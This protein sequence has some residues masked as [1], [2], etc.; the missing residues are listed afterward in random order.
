M[1]SGFT[2][3]ETLIALTIIALI[4]AISVPYL[5]I[6]VKRIQTNSIIESTTLGLRQFFVDAR[7]NSI[8]ENTKYT[9]SYEESN[10]SF[11]FAP[12][13][14]DLSAITY[15]V[16]GDF[17]KVAQIE[18]SPQSGTYDLTSEDEKYYFFKGLFVT[19]DPVGYKLITESF[20]IKI[21]AK[22]SN[23][24]AIERSVILTKGLAVATEVTS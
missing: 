20:G 13:D 11:T 10:H 15:T 5:Y 14:G 3:I 19:D 6:A 1:R 17:E 22:D 12:S 24:N 18:K 21:K 2:L 16:P 4:A 23:I 7:V 9:F 8:V